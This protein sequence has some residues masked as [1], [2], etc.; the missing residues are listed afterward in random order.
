MNRLFS[1]LWVL[2]LSGAFLAL[3]GVSLDPAAAGENWLRG[4]LV[5]I[6]GWGLVGVGFLGVAL[7]CYLSTRPKKPRPLIRASCTPRRPDKVAKSIY[8]PPAY[9]RYRY[10]AA[11]RR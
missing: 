7:A 9:R 11:R 6:L 5:G 8:T 10:D 2:L 3:W 4:R 1:R